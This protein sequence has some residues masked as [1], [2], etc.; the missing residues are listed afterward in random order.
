MVVE[1][2]RVYHQR[3]MWQSLVV[4]F[5][6]ELVL[7]VLTFQVHTPEPLSD[8]LAFTQFPVSTAVLFLLS[9]DLGQQIHA[10]PLGLGVA[11]WGIGVVVVILLLSAAIALPVWLALELLSPDHPPPKRPKA[12]YRRL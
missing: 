6:V 4:G 1:S 12:K 9:T 8:V 11:S 10:L 2:V 7:F 5:L 3:K